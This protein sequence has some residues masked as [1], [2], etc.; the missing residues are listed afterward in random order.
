MT[1]HKLLKTLHL[2]LALAVPI[3]S[4][5]VLGVINGLFSVQT[6]F[7]GEYIALLF[8]V[9]PITI[10]GAYAGIIFL[11]FFPHKTSEAL[12]LFIPSVFGFLFL[13]FHWQGWSWVQKYLIL[14]AVPTYLGIYLCLL[15]G[16]GYLGWKKAKAHAVGS[17]T[18]Q[19][20][21]YAIRGLV[22]LLLIAPIVGTSI[23]LVRFTHATIQSLDWSLLG[24][25]IYWSQIAISIGIY[26]PKLVKLYIAQKL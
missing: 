23:P 8:L 12:L 17:L 9:Y 22:L 4:L 18:D 19:T 13:I 3:F 24:E 11:N 7:W 25:L 21:A 16:L 1:L 5:V 10:F 2:F 26:Y 6:T 20:K 14:E 15:G